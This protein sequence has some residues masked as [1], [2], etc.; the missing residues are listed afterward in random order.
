MLER[1]LRIELR[2]L[3]ALEAVAE[4][5]SFSSAGSRLG[6][7]QSAVS[8]QIAALETIVGRR[9]VIRSR[10]SKP[11]ALTPEGRILYSHAKTILA[12]VR[13]AEADLAG[14]PAGDTLV[15]GSFQ[16]ISSRIVARVLQRLVGEVHVRLIE[17]TTEVGLVEQLTEGTIDVA[18]TEGP[19]PEGPYDAVELFEDPYV[20]VTSAGS[21][22][23][24]AGVAPTLRDVAALPLVGHSAARPRLVRHLEARGLDPTFVVHSDVNATIQSVV[25]NGVAHAVVPR[26]SVDETDDEVVVLPLDPP[27]AIEPRVM[28]LAWNTDRALDRPITRFV[29]AT[30]E[31]CAALDLAVTS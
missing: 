10:G 13:A 30:L 8:H 26:F 9:L 4:E 21:E 16:T 5:G 15:V 31:V 1:W 2:H 29:D 18:F 23:A 3:F 11:V 20:L 19:L 22:L 27:D 14:D 12:R 6:Y 28:L 24:E 25:R 7:V 17:H